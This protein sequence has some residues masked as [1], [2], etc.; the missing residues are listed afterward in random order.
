MTCAASTSFYSP[1][2]KPTSNAVEYET[3]KFEG[4]FLSENV[5]KG[6]PNKQL[7]QAWDRIANANLSVVG[8]EVID[9]LGV[10]RGA[11]KYSDEN[12][13]QYMAL[14]EAV[15]Q[16]H[17]LNVVRMYTWRD[18]YEKPENKPVEFTDQESTVR[19]HVDHC[20]DMLRQ[21]LMCQAD[22][23]IVPF[24]WVKGQGPSEDFSTTHKCRNFDKIVQWAEDHAEPGYKA[25]SFPDSLWLKELPS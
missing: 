9:G 7:D 24:Y 5:Y 21:V 11:V 23:G 6:R 3:I 22:V 25:V 8:V 17:C 20:I 12:G 2:L 15:H 10:S 13:G 4:G 18:Y 16:L 19:L 14:L 1:L